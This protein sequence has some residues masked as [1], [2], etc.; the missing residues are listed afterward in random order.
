M[1]KKAE[2]ERKGKKRC[3]PLAVGIPWLRTSEEK[4]GESLLLYLRDCSENVWVV[5]FA[6][7]GKKWRSLID[8][9]ILLCSLVSLLSLSLSLSGSSRDSERKRR[10]ALASSSLIFDV[11]KWGR[12]I[13]VYDEFFGDFI[14]TKWRKP[15]GCFRAVR[16]KKFDRF[17]LMRKRNDAAR[18]TLS[19]QER[20][21]QLISMKNED[22][23]RFTPTSHSI[24]SRWKAHLSMLLDSF[25]HSSQDASRLYLP[26]RRT[27]RRAV[28]QPRWS[29]PSRHGIERETCLSRLTTPQTR[30]SLSFICQS[31]PRINGC[32]LIFIRVLT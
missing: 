19:S 10:R 17:F 11:C 9:V 31:F 6:R 29:S 5:W 27:T 28:R 23:H 13:C 2:G 32:R 21:L 8:S 1:S 18:E 4:H 26:R 16:R 7:L 30:C 24:S 15:N 12:E 20:S 14:K 25:R 3:F 22:T